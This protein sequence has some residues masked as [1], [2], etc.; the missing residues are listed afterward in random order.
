[1]YLVLLVDMLLVKGHFHLLRIS[2]FACEF[3]AP[4]SLANVL[5]YANVRLWSGNNEFACEMRNANASGN[6]PLGC[7]HTK[8][9]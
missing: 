2:K 6:G 8:S 1:M 3:I 7:V 4:T 9:E 5:R